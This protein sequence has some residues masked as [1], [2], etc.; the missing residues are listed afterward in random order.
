MAVYFCFQADSIG[1]V[2]Q[3]HKWAVTQLLIKGN[4]KTHETMLNNL[5]NSIY[6]LGK[7]Y[8]TISRKKNYFV[9]S[10]LIFLLHAY[11]FYF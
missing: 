9:K 3:K 10:S 11:V 5:A 1:F 6:L 2:G 4:N 8:M 7:Y